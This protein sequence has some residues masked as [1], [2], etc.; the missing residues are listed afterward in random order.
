LASLLQSTGGSTRLTARWLLDEPLVCTRS[1]QQLHGEGYD[2]PNT[3]HMSAK[4]PTHR[5]G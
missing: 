1:N 5:C 2:G 4:S 3:I